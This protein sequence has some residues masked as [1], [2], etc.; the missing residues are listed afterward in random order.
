[1][2]ASRSTAEHKGE[3]DPEDRSNFFLPT[4]LRFRDKILPLIKLALLADIE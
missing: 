3:D 4:N 1:M 2:H